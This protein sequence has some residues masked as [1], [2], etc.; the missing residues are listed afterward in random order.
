[1]KKILITLIVLMIIVSS[2]VFAQ[3]IPDNFLIVGDKVIELGYA[4]E[5]KE[6][7]NIILIDFFAQGGSVEGLYIALNGSLFDVN[8]NVKTEVQKQEIISSCVILID[9]DHP[10]GTPIGTGDLEVI[11]IY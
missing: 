5:N 3:E 8:M 9:K 11:S 7:F 4:M 6:A 10:N 2:T 1:M